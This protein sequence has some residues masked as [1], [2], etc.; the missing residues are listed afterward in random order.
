LVLKLALENGPSGYGECLARTYVTGESAA[1][2]Y[3]WFEAQGAAFLAG[4]DFSDV[5]AFREFLLAPDNGLLEGPTRCLIELAL[6]DAY[7]RAFAVAPSELFGRAQREC[8]VYAGVIGG[9]S[10]LIRRQLLGR[11]KEGGLRYLKVKVGFGKADCEA[12]RDCRE[13]FGDE[14][15]I[16]LDANSAWTARTS[17]ERLHELAAFAPGFVEQPVA[18]DDHE[19]LAEVTRDSPIPVVLDETVCTVADAE[20]AAYRRL[21]HGF[22]V[23][24]SKVGGFANALRIHD[25]AQRYGLRFHIGSMVGETGILAAAGRHLATM[26]APLMLEGSFG[27][28]LL[29]EDL[30]VPSIRFGPGGIGTGLPGP[31]LGINVDDRR[32]AKYQ[33]RRWR[34]AQ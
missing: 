16:G 19:A 15:V 14:V 10:G 2:V 4:L 18:R 23:R 9:M 29:R 32:I 31:G 13:T 3:S 28:L 26:T 20:V 7:G 11:M 5:G 24:L 33:V 1:S 30:T 6:L 21:G 27:D 34:F 12:L 17:L 22:N 8:C 25:V